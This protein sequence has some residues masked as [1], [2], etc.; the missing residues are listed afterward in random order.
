M[1]C[2]KC[3]GE[4]GTLE[5]SP[6]CICADGPEWLHF[7][8]P[9]HFARGLEEIEEVSVTRRRATPAEQARCRE[10][11][12]GPDSWRAACPLHGKGTL[13]IYV[14]Y[15]E[16]TTDYPGEWVVRRQTVVDGEVIVDAE[17]AAR[18]PTKKECFGDLLLKHPH[19]GSM[20]YLAR[21]ADDDPVIDGTF[22]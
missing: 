4:V 9:L 17:L 5:P 6:G 10:L 20:T 13:P 19:V 1:R 14:V 3:G 2:V 21:S 15:N 11:G 12:C 22:L 16:R 8:G 18:G 7:E